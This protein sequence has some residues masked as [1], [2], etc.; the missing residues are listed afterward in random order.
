MTSDLSFAMAEVYRNSVESMEAR[1]GIEPTNEGFAD[2]S[3]TTW[4][5]RH[6]EQYR[7]VAVRVPTSF[8]ELLD[9]SVVMSFNRHLQNIEAFEAAQTLDG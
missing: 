9:S 5:P 3:L 8:A 7:V 2:L 1:V 4:V 6:V